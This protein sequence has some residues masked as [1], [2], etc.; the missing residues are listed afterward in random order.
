[1]PIPPM[2]WTIEPVDAGEA[3]QVTAFIEHVVMTSVDAS[4]TEKLAVMEN[5]R[6][7]IAAWQ[8]NPEPVLHLKVMADGQLVGV[9]MVKAWWNLCHLFVAPQRQ[10]QGVGRALMMA[11]IAACRG[12]SPRQALRLNASRNA[13]AFYRRLGFELVADAPPPFTGVQYEIKL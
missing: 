12:K 3:P 13:A 11:A 5:I 4:D 6:A 9:V 7:N 8:R 2:D 1:M 10:Q